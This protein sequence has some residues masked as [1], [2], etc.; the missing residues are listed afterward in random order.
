MANDE[1]VPHLQ[2][3][4]NPRNSVSAPLEYHMVREPLTR[5][6]TVV[7]SKGSFASDPH[8]PSHHAMGFGTHLNAIPASNSHPPSRFHTPPRPSYRGGYC[9]SL[10]PTLGNTNVLEEARCK[11]KITMLTDWRNLAKHYC[12]LHKQSSTWFSNMNM[13]F[14]IPIIVLSSA[15]GAVGFANAM[16]HYTEPDQVNRYLQIAMGGLGIVT[17]A[18]TTISNYLKLGSGIEAHNIISREFEKLARD[19]SVQILL[20]STE[21]KTFASLA[22][23]IKTVNERFNRL[24]EIAP[25]IPDTIWKRNEAKA[26]I[27]K[28]KSFEALSSPATSLQV[29]IDRLS[30]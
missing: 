7:E 23:Y 29:S 8:P 28:Y 5:E 11:E 17:A 6:S 20:N 4:L 14:T 27:L 3:Q 22:E 2:I 30:A 18:L 9:E 21:E 12:T 25:D 1:N 13:A 19:I 24:L 10:G 26:P 15:T 16:D